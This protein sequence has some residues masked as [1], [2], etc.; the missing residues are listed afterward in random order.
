MQGKAY[1]IDNHG[2]QISECQKRL[3]RYGKLEYFGPNSFDPPEFT[4]E[5]PRGECRYWG[6]APLNLDELG[7]DT[8]FIIY[9]AVGA[10]DDVACWRWRTSEG[11][12]LPDDSAAIS[13]LCKLRE[14][15]LRN[16]VAHLHSF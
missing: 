8:D 2:G 15:D 9:K 3:P 10:G 7:I 11:F 4:T 14:D 5:P 1:Q 6:G 16:T 12:G 13:H